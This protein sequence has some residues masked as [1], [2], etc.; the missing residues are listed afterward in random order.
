M[1][2]YDTFLL[3][4]GPQ[5]LDLLEC[6]LYEL[7]DCG[8]IY[9]HVIVEGRLTV[10]GLPKPLYYAENRERF[11]AWADKI[12]YVPIL[13]TTEEPGKE[14]GEAWAREHSSRQACRSGLWDAE[15]DDVIVHGDLDEIMTTEAVSEIAVPAREWAPHKLRQRHFSFA[16]DW[17]QPWWWHAPS[18]A[19][20]GQIGSFTVLRESGWPVWEMPSGEPAGW[21]LSWLGGPEAMTAKAYSFT[22]TEVVPMVLEAI[23]SGKFYEQGMWT[24]GDPDGVWHDWE[25]MA[26]VDVDETW[27]RWVYERKC[28]GIWFRPRGVPD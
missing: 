12:R 18:V 11:A 4:S 25:H 5:D 28:P 14:P 16:V 8:Q 27:P 15:P 10:T 24:G 26:A 21:H 19:R 22:H 9:R 6:R 17:Q 20:F 1:K 23:A 3:G 13:P 2:V 7:G